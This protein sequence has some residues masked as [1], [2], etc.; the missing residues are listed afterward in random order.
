MVNS[1]GALVAMFASLA[2]MTLLALVVH[3][4]M[5]LRVYG[6]Q[7]MFYTALKDMK[8]HCPGVPSNELVQLTHGRSTNGHQEEL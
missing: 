3:I 5:I 2:F 6:L 7:R 4:H 8:R 1:M